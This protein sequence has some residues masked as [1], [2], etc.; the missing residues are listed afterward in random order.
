MSWRDRIE[1]TE[2]VA[3]KKTWK[4][5][6]ERVEPVDISKTES[7]TRGAFDSASFG[8]LD[9]LAGGLEALGS[10]V[11][12]RGLG[13][14]FN[15]IR[16]E[17][18]EEDAQ[19]WDAVY[20]EA[21]DK[22]RTQSAGAMEANPLS[23]GAGEVVGGITSG[24][25]TGNV[26]TGA[27]KMLG[28]T[29]GK[30]LGAASIRAAGAGAVDGAVTG[31]VYS[32]AEDL[33]GIA[34]DAGRGAAISGVLGGVMP[35]VGKGLNKATAG[36]TK[37]FNKIAL[38]LDEDISDTLIKNPTYLDNVK[39][40]N[41]IEREAVE[42]ANT[43]SGTI[44]QWDDE[45]WK[46]LSNVP[47]PANQQ[48]SI[49]ANL[50]QTIREQLEQQGH[51]RRG[52]DG[53][54]FAVST[55]QSRKAIAQ[56]EEVIGLVKQSNLSPQELKR[57]VKTVDAEINWDKQ[58]L[59]ASNKLMRSI[60]HEI[61]D[62]LKSR[63]EGYRT[64]MEDVA[65]GVGLLED[66]RKG[67]RLKKEVGGELVA[68]DTTEKKLNTALRGNRN[69]TDK[70]LRENLDKLSNYRTNSSGVSFVE[71][72]SK[73]EM[74]R[75][76][77]GGVTNGSRG[78]IGGSVLGLIFGGGVNYYQTG[79][80]N[81][82]TLAL[83]AAGGA[84]GLARDKYG[85]SVGK[86]ISQLVGQMQNNYGKYFAG[87]AAGGANKMAVNHYLLYNKDEEYRKMYDEIQK[88]LEK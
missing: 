66:T 28:I 51:L 52:V 56:A 75:R 14:S 78:V 70:V 44:S 21:R 25:A 35:V 84:A 12:V 2:D 88:V 13:G 86:G 50:T 77:T 87:A 8:W 26:A 80:L 3:P 42:A 4:D 24:V 31:A 19:D 15:D 30:G 65:G 81:L 37:K 41:Q 34:K 18:D 76:A 7:F 20:K 55:P 48:V 33:S 17:T 43:L 16:L 36:F 58:E 5:R 69:D 23:Y 68:T 9:E 85:R 6:I 82:G 64:A 71:D 57:I 39:P 59:A 54:L 83:G 61:D 63:N 62:S 67:L 22:R 1:T 74:D 53:E 72:L 45:A 73:L 40:K 32:Q 27:G 38:D 11:G 29:A 79:E 10:K 46:Q 60:R 47:F 49:K